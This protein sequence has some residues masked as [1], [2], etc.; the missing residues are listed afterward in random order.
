MTCKTRVISLAQIS[1]VSTARAASR[2]AAQ[3]RRQRRRQQRPPRVEGEEEVPP[4]QELQRAALPRRC[5]ARPPRREASAPAPPP[6][7]RAA[8]PPRRC[9]RAL[10]CRVQNHRDPSL[11][12][13]TTR[14]V[15][16][17]CASALRTQLH[18]TPCVAQRLPSSSL[19]SGAAAALQLTHR[20]NPCT[21]LHR[22]EPTQLRRERCRSRA[23]T[24]DCYS[25]QRW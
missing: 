3:R 2:A 13:A 10:D 17:L 7:L 1:M 24:L 11:D 23:A 14:G 25:I 22:R 6:S 18:R 9:D 20:P 21:R 4:V 15:Q 12:R 8:A 5:R 16:K 19:P